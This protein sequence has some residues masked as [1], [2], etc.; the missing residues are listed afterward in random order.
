M[1]SE[2]SASAACARTQSA[3]RTR[4][5]A[6]AVASTIIFISVDVAA[7][8]ACWSLPN[9]WVKASR[10]ACRYSSLNSGVLV[11]RQAVT[12]EIPTT[13]AAFSIPGCCSSARINCS[14]WR[15][16]RIT[17]GS[18]ML[19]TP[20]SSLKLVQIRL[21]SWCLWSDESSCAVNAAQKGP[22]TYHDDRRHHQIG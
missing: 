3:A 21:A 1:S 4:L 19:V 11:I 6:G 18:D 20:L 5:A 10:R 9:D 12:V 2:S 7:P 22:P 8:A 13:A 16:R 15:A 17:L 14:R